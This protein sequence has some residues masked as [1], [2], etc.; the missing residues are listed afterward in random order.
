M[1]KQLV[2]DTVKFQV[3]GGQ[4]TPAPPVGTVAG[5]ASGSTS[6]SSFSSSTISTKEANGMPIPVVVSTCTTTE[7][8]TSKRR[9]PLRPSL[10]KQAAGIAKGLGRAKQRKGRQRSPVDATR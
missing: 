4:A 6:V 9:A 3:P 10:L 2:K 1:A 5:K 7:P 8:S